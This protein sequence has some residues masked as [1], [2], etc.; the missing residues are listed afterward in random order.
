MLLTEAIRT[1]GL[2]TGLSAGLA[3][4]RKPTAIHDPANFLT[5]LAVG[6]GLGGDCLADLPSWASLYMST[7]SARASR[8]D[9]V[10]TALKDCE[11]RL[12]EFAS[13]VY[14]ADSNAL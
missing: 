12:E 14:Q 7:M 6:Q 10:L 3:R 1:S 8:A 5:D 11:A 9:E 4:A 13:N 2:D